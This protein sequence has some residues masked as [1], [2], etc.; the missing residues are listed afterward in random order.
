MVFDLPSLLITAQ[1]AHGDEVKAEIS[2]LGEHPMQGG[3]ILKRPRNDRL[4]GVI[5]DLEALEPCRPSAVQ[6]LAH[7]NL[8]LCRPLRTAHTWLRFRAG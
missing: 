7:P 1:T 5:P 8:V 6:D 2:D 3:L 4:A